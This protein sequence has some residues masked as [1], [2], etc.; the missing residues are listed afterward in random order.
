MKQF[1]STAAEYLSHVECFMPTTSIDSHLPE[2]RKYKRIKMRQEFTHDA[3]LTHRHAFMPRKLFSIKLQKSD[4]T[5]A[6]TEMKALENA[7]NLR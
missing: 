2:N 3:R 5:E 1:V 4:E 6:K 7:A